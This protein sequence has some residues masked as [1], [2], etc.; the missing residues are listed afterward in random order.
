MN[1]SKLIIAA[2]LATPP[3]STMSS[4]E[5][6]IWAVETG[7]SGGP[8]VG[9]GGAALGPLQIHECCWQDVR[10]EDEEYSDCSSL[11]YSLVVFRRYMGRYATEGRLGE[12]TDESRAR[13]WNGGPRAPWATGQK[14]ANLDRYWGRVKAAMK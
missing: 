6:A 8:V 4:L 13:I 12:V 3:M 7:R 5:D 14:K 1:L 10:L 9:D 11:A 2:I